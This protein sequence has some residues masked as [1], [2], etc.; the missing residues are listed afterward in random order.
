MSANSAASRAIGHASAIRRSAT[1]SHGASRDGGHAADGDHI[2]LY[3]SSRPAAR[4]GAAR[5]ASRP[6]S[7]PDRE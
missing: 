6:G 2:D 1:G 5:R 3:Q 7:L 4:A